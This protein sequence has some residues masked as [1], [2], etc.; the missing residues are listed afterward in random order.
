MGYPYKEKIALFAGASWK[1]G[2]SLLDGEAKKSS[3]MGF[4]YGSSR[5]EITARNCSGST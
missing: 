4:D 3:W 1:N 5:S 2:Q